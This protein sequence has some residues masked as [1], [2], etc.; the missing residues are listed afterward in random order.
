MITIHKYTAENKQE[1]NEF[2]LKSRNGTFLFLRDYMNYHSDRFCDHSLMYK[3]AKGR[4]VAVMP[5]NEKDGVLH[6]HQG[7]TYGGIVMAEELRAT[8]VE[9]IFSCTKEY[10]KQH[11]FHEW[12]YKQMPDIYHLIPSEE[13]EYWLWRNGAELSACGISSTIRLQEPVVKMERLRKRCVK[14]AQ[15]A[16]YTVEE[17]APLKDFWPIMEKN[18]MER[19][20]VKPV[21]TLEEMQRLQNLLPEYIECYLCR[22]SSGDPVGGAVIYKSNSKVV[23]VQYAHANAE[24]KQNG[25]IDLLYAYLLEKYA[26]QGYTYYDIGISTE[27]KGRKLND[28]LIM[29]KE[30]FGARGITYKQWKI[31]FAFLLLFS[32]TSF[33]QQKVGKLH[34]RHIKTMRLDE[35]SMDI[36]GGFVGSDKAAQGINLPQAFDG[37]GVVVGITDI[38]FDFTHP[39]FASTNIVSFWDMLSTDTLYNQKKLLVGR[40]YDKW[41]LRALKH[42]YDGLLQTH[43]THVMGSAVGGDSKYRGIAPKADVVVVGNVLSNNYKQLD[44]L[45]QIKLENTPGYKIDEFRYMFE[46]ADRLGKPCVINISAGSRQSFGDD[47]PIYNEHISELCGPGRIIVASAGNNGQQLVTLHK[48]T[49]KESVGS[50]AMITNSELCYLFFQKKGDVECQLLYSEKEGGEKKLVPDTLYE[51]ID[52]VSDY[53]GSF[54]RYYILEHKKME[55]KGEFFYARLTGSGE[56]SLYTQDVLFQNSGTNDG[57]NDAIYD[58][59]VNFP[60]CYDDV[61]CV[62]GVDHRNGFVNPE[63]KQL[64]ANNGE[65]GLHYRFTSVGPRLDGYQKPDICAPASIVLSSYNSFYEEENPT[66]EDLGWIKERVEYNGRTYSWNA[67]SGTSQAAPIVSGIIALWLQAN[68]NLTPQDIKDIFAHTAHHPDP[69]LTYPNNIYGY[70][71]ID[72]YAGLLYILGIDKIE[73]VSKEQAK[74][75]LFSM[76]DGILTITPNTMGDN[77]TSTQQQAAIQ[78]FTTSGQ[79]VHQESVSL[80]D[81]PQ[82]ISL[83]H[84]PKGVYA[85]QVNTGNI[86]GSNLIRR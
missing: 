33:A 86:K 34:P 85:V 79:L 55:G 44:S 56:G 71:E 60:G 19:Y 28:S 42:S 57:F 41:E 70:G 64:Y 38:G 62:G 10:L 2:V 21:H 14:K 80:Y 25:A 7:L 26:N 48:P 36:S 43:G 18:L 52:T 29:Y 35:A 11:G 1:W 69:N 63:G 83:Q 4:L 27:D 24:G 51:A 40:D 66:A 22:N 54:V 20:S 46:Q 30:G 84:L 49:G 81:T 61:I 32:L 65:I 16:G 68:P 67:N 23:H 6:S 15:E 76:R 5:A 13:D 78:I 58:Y 9:E 50:R 12:T 39:N 74:D 59:S 3:N 53:D 31:V 37:S 47:F 8:D 73:A 17:N 45:Q 72:A 75:L 77:S 82:T